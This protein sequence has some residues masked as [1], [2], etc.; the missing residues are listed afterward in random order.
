MSVA[1]GKYNSLQV[2]RKVDFG[3]Y[4]DAGDG[5]ILM[6]KRYVTPDMTIGSLVTAFV[7]FDSE[8]RPIATTEKPTAQVGEFAYLR[9]KESNKYGTFLQWLPSKDLLL[10]HSNQLSASYTKK[11]RFVYI[12]QDE[13]THRIVA[14]EKINK[15]LN[16]HEI[17]YQTGDNVQIMVYDVIDIG[18]KVIVDNQFVGIVYSNETK[19]KLAL[20]NR[21]N[22]YVS[23][24]RE[25]DRLDLSLTPIGFAKT[26]KL[27]EIILQKLHQNNGILNVSDKSDPTEIQQLF[28]CSKKSFKMT[29]GTLYHQKKINIAEN[30]ITLK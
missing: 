4:L 5:E 28:G 17:P 12:Y 15:Y 11:A 14:T 29:I 23:R 3:I 30:T 7:Y 25:D 26:E 2:T 22:A 8:D 27:A 9:A 16:N 18:Y 13:I 20:G 1:F 21:S 6:P 24:I 10:P 19:Q